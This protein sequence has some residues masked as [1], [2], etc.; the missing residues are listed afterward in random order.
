REA[1]RRSLIRLLAGSLRREA[2]ME[3][4]TKTLARSRTHRLLWMVY[5]GAA[6]AVLLNS[7]L[8]DG[9]YLMRSKGWGIALQ[10]LVIF[11]PLTCTVVILAGFRH[12]LSWNCA[13]TGFSRSPKAR[14]GRSG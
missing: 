2:V 5:L 14:G 6:A 4:F 3:F 7:S 9:A 8:I 1:R 10:F 12:V 13:P 11:W